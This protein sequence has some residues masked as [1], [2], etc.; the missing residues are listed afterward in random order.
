MTTKS[1]QSTGHLAEEL[2][3]QFHVLQKKLTKARNSYLA[4]HRKEVA[5]ARERMQG[6]QSQLAKARKKAAKAAVDARRSG[7]KS[8]KNQ[9]KKARAASLLL[10]DSLTEARDIMVTAQSRLHAAKP[11]DRKLAARARVLAQF[12]KDW[13]RK[14]QEEFETRAAK[15]KKAAAKRR[16]TAK[17]RA[18]KK[19]AAKVPA[20]IASPE[21]PAQ[22]KT[23]SKKSGKPSVTAK[24][25]RKQAG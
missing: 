24:K 25:S 11:F 4:V 14:L 10:A 7:T 2:E 9:L 20:A 5:A 21:K 16:T 8:A 1:G 13:E 6:L 3:K 22:K 18:A 17:K 15:A 19:V 12:E 23:A